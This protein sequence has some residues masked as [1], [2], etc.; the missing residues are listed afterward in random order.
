MS[1]NLCKS[2]PPIP[3][4]YGNVIYSIGSISIDGHKLDCDIIPHFFFSDFHFRCNHS[5][6]ISEFSHRFDF[7]IYLRQLHVTIR[8]IDAFATEDSPNYQNL[9]TIS[10]TYRG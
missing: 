2:L 7:L 6:G 3:V 5:R 1:E 10:A 8:V 9:F 4:L